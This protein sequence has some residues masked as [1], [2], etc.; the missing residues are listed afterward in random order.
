MHKSIQLLAYSQWLC[1]LLDLYDLSLHFCLGIF[2]ADDSIR[3]PSGDKDSQ[4]EQQVG[5]QSNRTSFGSDIDV[6]VMRVPQRVRPNSY[7]V[8]WVGISIVANTHTEDGM[9]KEH[10]QPGDPV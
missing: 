7:K 8:M 4:R 1:H 9:G 5:S 2:L 10:T 3:V 6:I